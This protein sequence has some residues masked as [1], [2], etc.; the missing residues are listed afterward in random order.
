MQTT[1]VEV[2]FD[3]KQNRA[4][5]RCTDNLYWLREAF[6]KA[7]DASPEKPE[8]YTREETITEMV[9]KALG[10]FK[11]TDEVLEISVAGGRII[12]ANSRG[13]NILTRN[14]GLLN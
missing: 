12:L 6:G 9:T 2:V 5:T 7:Y 14:P 13:M 11:P 8:G 10:M 4:V 3:Q 1:I